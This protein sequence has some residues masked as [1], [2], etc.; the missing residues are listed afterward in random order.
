L[1]G[2]KAVFSA[3]NH[4]GKTGLTVTLFLIGTGLSART[5]KEVGVRPL[6]QGVVLWAVVGSASLAA[7]YWNWIGI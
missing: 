5:L 2:G 1:P 4:L 7:I 3:L 6:V